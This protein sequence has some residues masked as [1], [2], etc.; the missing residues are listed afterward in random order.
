MDTFTTLASLRSWL[1]AQRMAGRSIGFVPTMGAL[2]RGHLTLIEAAAAGNEVVVVSI[3]VNP[4]QFAAHEDLASYPRDLERDVAM[5]TEVGATAI[6]APSVE[7]MYPQWPLLTS[8]SV[9]TIS[10][11]MEGAVRPH[12][13]AGVATVVCKLFS[14]VGECRAYFGEKDFQQLAVVRRMTEDL[15]LPVELVGCPTVRERDGL[16]MS[17]RNVYLTEEERQQAP[18]LHWALIAA[19][20]AI[21]SGERSAE[22]VR[23]LMHSL[24]EPVAPLD[25]AE[26]VD[27]Y[28]LQ[29]VDP[30]AGELRLLVAARFGKARLI[31]NVGVTVPPIGPVPT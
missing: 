12:F 20:A 9:S 1:H 2:H 4:L 13:F 3:F 30:L 19:V 25:Y 16:A 28:S 7:E 11:P 26:V 8:V 5:A 23:Q 21:A 24:I 22:S 14:I 15:S 31:D 17:S 6:F 29:R 18:T 27:A 10:E